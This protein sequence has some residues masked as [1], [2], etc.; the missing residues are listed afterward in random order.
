MHACS[1]A[2]TVR[3]EP[4][5]IVAARA[6][7]ANRL[8]SSRSVNFFRDGYTL[9]EVHFRYPFSRHDFRCDGRDSRWRFVRGR[10]YPASRHDP[11][12]SVTF[13]ATRYGS[14]VLDTSELA[15]IV[16][17]PVSVTSQLPGTL[18]KPDASPNSS[19]MH[20]RQDNVKVNADSI[21]VIYILLYIQQ[22]W[23]ER[24]TGITSHKFTC[25]QA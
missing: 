19:H 8:G 12:R 5:R 18:R 9:A 10:N 11:S 15:A 6:N 3:H 16:S 14:G 4:S 1:T 25:M 7:L 21:S 13:Y 17:L 24:E 22:P 2:V 20:R 23:M